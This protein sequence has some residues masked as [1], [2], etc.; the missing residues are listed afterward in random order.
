MTDV[1]PTSQRSQHPQDDGGSAGD[2]AVPASPT[3]QRLA[4]FNV[5]NMVRSLLPLVVICL[6]IVG[7]TTLRQGPDERVQT[8]DPSTTV[9]LAAARASYPVQAPSGLAKEFL[10]TSAR[11]NAG[12]VTNG[13][14][15][16][17][18]IGYLTPAKQFAG[19]TESDDP[20]AQPVHDVLDGATPHGTT[21]IGGVQWT[22]STT[23][24]GETAFS[25]TVG[26][27][28]LV[29]SGSASDKE[30][31]TVAASVRPYSG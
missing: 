19:F 9:Q 17:L 6:I 5:A 3:M 29:V 26:G 24:R 28:T 15:V 1:G 8:V 20:G 4:R 16:T 21:D 18:E 13:G 12:N 25:R 2:G 11:T 14:P 22:R 30:L 27:V 10:P 31:T 23:E 7:W